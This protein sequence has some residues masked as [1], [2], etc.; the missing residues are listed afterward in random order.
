MEISTI[1][2][3]N[4]GK[5]LATGQKG[6]IFQKTPDAPVIIWSYETK[7]PLA[8]LK[9]V[10][11]CV[12]RLQFSPDDKFLACIGQNNTFIIWNVQDGTPIHTRV[13]EAPFTMLVWGDIISDVNPKHPTY[14]VISGSHQ[15]VFINK[16]EF[17]ISSMQYFLKASVCQL[18]NTGLIRSY[19]FAKV[20][21]DMLLA[22]TTGGEIC[23]FSIAS[24]I[25]RASMPLTSNGI[26]C[27]AVDKDFLYVGGGDGKIKKVALA[28]GSWTLTHEAALDSRVMS[29]N[30]S[31]DG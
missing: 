3:S 19:T 29:V 11:D 7:K 5:L 4:S 8:V 23:V 26:L 24:A 18:P 20:Q 15:N 1:A 17:D 30:L 16:L 25:Y 2:V 27:G 28:G 9:G 21:G 6:T 10:T 22:G 12:N 14:T 31:N 13:S